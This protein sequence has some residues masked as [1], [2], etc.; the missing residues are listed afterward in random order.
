MKPINILVLLL[1]LS[2]LAGCASNY[3]VILTNGRV[4]TT[5]TKPKLDKAKNRYVFKDTSGQPVEVAPVL[6]REIAPTS[7]SEASKFT[8][9]PAR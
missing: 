4:Y 2:L 5:S 8:S 3:N 6:V 9:T 1:V 7:M